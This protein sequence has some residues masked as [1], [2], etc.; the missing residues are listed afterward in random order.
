MERIDMQNGDPGCTYYQNK[1]GQ[2]FY[3]LPS[4]RTFYY[5]P[6][7]EE[8]ALEDEGKQAKKDDDKQKTGVKPEPEPSEKRRKTR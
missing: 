5:L 8:Y 7:E 2:V 1:E 6:S 3:K 4:D